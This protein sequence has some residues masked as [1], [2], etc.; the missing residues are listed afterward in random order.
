[1]VRDG[2][3]QSRPVSWVSLL[4]YLDPNTKR[5]PHNLKYLYT[6]SLEIRSNIL[7]GCLPK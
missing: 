4:T 5:V 3:L 7:L 1:M 6:S 2:R